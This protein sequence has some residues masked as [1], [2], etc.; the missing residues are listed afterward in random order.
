MQPDKDTAKT[1]TQE[2]LTDSERLRMIYQMITSP[3]AD[4]GAGI[5]PK[6]GDWEN[7]DS[8]FPLHDHVRNK[9]WLNDFSKKTLL[10]PDDLDQIRDTVGE[11]VPILCG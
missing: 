8:I 9:R 10:T 5:T 6:H 11:K 2:P 3:L 4:G 7:V 1:L